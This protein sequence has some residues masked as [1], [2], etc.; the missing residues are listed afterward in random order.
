MP[1]IISMFLLSP[2]LQCPLQDLRHCCHTVQSL[3]YPCLFSANDLIHTHCIKNHKPQELQGVF[4]HTPLYCSSNPTRT[5]HTLMSLPPQ[6][7]GVFMPCFLLGWM[8]LHCTAL[9]TFG[10][11]FSTPLKRGCFPLAPI[12]LCPSVLLWLAIQ[13]L[14]SLQDVSHSARSS[15]AILSFLCSA[16]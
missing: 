14:S 11:A 5:Q 6:Q 13:Q 4:S 10:L 16:M 7:T 1:P 8:P 15:P 3:L 9:H 12:K 2:P